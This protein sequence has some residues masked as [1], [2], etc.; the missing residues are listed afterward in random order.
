[1]LAGDTRDQSDSVR[2]SNSEG[3][4]RWAA[5]INHEAT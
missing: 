4:P 3:K 2:M 5:L 1:M